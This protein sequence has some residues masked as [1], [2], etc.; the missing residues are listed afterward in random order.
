[1][2]VDTA[3][4]LDAAQRRV[5]DLPAD[6]SG[7]VIGSP[8][9]GKSTTVCERVAHLLTTGA[10]QPDELLVLTPTR[11]TATALRDRLALAA[12]TATP[13]PLA[14]SV[15]SFAFQLVRAEAARSGEDPPQ[16]LTG[17]DEDQLVQDL[18]AG[19]ETDA[20]HGRERWPAWLSAEIRRSR[21]F[22]AEVRAFLAEC[23]DLG[24]EPTRLR[25]L[26]RRTQ[27][28]V[29][30]SMASFSGEYLD[31]RAAMRGAHRDAA[32]LVREAAALLARPGA[33]GPAGVRGEPA[34]LD[35]LRVLMV[36]DAQEIT[37][38]GV[39]LLLAARARGISVLAFGDPDVSSG[40]FRGASTHHLA[41]LASRWGAV[42]VLDTPHRG[43]GSLTALT[44]SVTERIGTSGLVEHR[45]SAFGDAPPM[46]A[47]P[48]EAREPSVRAMVLR[49]P[50]EEY[51]AIARLLRE[52][53]VFDGISWDQCAVIAHDSR[54]VVALEAELAARDVP[55]RASSRG[56]AGALGAQA[57]VRDV[58]T[59]LV[60]ASRAPE[61]WQPEEVDA[62]LSGALCGLDAVG[63]RRLRLALRRAEA[64]AGGERPV[65]EVLRSA[66]AHPAELVP[67]ETR[68][69]GR[70]ARAGHLLARLRDG[71][72]AGETV[73]EL[74]W[75][76]WEGSG[77]ERQWLAAAS[78]GG[79]LAEQA[80]RDLDAFV[81]LFEA[82]KRFVERAPDED[83]MVFVRHVR[84]SDVAE[85]SLTPAALRPVVRVMTPAAAL[86][87]EFD[88]V[89]VAGVQD[90]VWPNV[91]LR[92]SLLDTWRIADAH[93]EKPASE[94]DVLDRRRAAMHD[95]LRLFARAVSRARAMLVVTAVD[96]DDSG[97]SAFLD[98]LPT[99]ASPPGLGHPLS[100]RGLVA[101][102]RRTLTDGASSRQ[103]RAAAAEQLV[104]LGEAG[105][106]G[107]SPAQWYGML[108][109]TSHEPLRALP[110]EPVRVSPS[111]IHGF[112]E[113]ELDAVVSDLGGRTRTVSAG[114]GTI[115]HSA[116]EHADGDDE[117]ALW[118]IVDARWHELEFDARWQERAER[119]RAQDLVGRL[120]R[121]LQRFRNDGGTLLD[122][123]SGF[124]IDLPLDPER[125]D[126][127]ERILLSGYIDRVEVTPAGEIV[128]VDLK[129]GRREP[130]TDA[131]VADHPQLASY[132]LAFE[133]GLIAGAAG[134]APGGAKLL[135]LVPSAT[136]SDWAEPHQPP[137]DDDARQA[138]LERVRAVARTMAGARFVAPYEEHC[139]KD[140]SHGVCRIHTVG[141]VSAP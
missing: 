103:R 118:A 123:E 71:L 4:K 81:A 121:Y 26:A 11:Q 8:G 75:S 119:R 83:P 98:L 112:E 106:A 117:D 27:R 56:S 64:A 95:E 20:R 58:L 42:H 110:D 10:L 137:F 97:P 92:G 17:A 49:S 18:L 140:H 139:R 135:I 38:G 24:V 7:V 62:V 1:M 134:H 111:K 104:L 41:T 61:D 93:A 45:R 57:P 34:P 100:L 90:G 65:R 85:D 80:G 96:D 124:Q 68:E 15:A 136:R 133:H 53:H 130:Q 73:H 99:P 132:Q 47:D 79:V 141:A 109:P 107:A 23:A 12:G 37:T 82:A 40:A 22:R 48:F 101:Q 86:G 105:V 127:G 21:P 55:I 50:S 76:A 88:T 25:T 52:R 113:C 31:V 126:A 72:A 128:I 125:P 69:A 120:H 14:R 115:L 33:Q 44:R 138:F 46:D 74:L 39:H 6:A 59:A 16:L 43:D 122:V 94:D 28:D 30:A 29:W 78:S 3:R 54:Q 51:D 70:A 77:L 67:I 129:T 116:L 19:D 89:V 36:D 2:H 131:K 84:D 9:T 87:R 66:L 102:H 5:V 32:G 108:P 60:L 63:L 35:R 114:L 13:G 91:R